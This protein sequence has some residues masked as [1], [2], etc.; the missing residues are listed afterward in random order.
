[1]DEATEIMTALEGGQGEVV[2][3]MIESDVELEG[4]TIEEGESSHVMIEVEGEVVV[5][6]EEDVELDVLIGESEVTI[7][8]DD[9][10]VETTMEAE[11]EDMTIGVDETTIE[12]PVVAV[13]VK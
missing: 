11:S 7:E 2:D 12:E 1:M 10:R 6:I 4:A 3:V 8:E 13:V 9:F 5:M